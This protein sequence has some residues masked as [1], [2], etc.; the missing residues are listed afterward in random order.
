MM[1]FSVISLFPEMIEQGLSGLVAS[2]KNKGLYDLKVCDLRSFGKGVHKAVDDQIYGGTD[3][4]LLQAEPLAE[5]LQA[6]RNSDPDMQDA[7][8]VFLSP[9][10]QVWKQEKAVQWAKSSAPKILIC[11]RYAGVDQ[12]FIDQHC[13]LEISIGDFILNGGELAA[14]V[15]MESVIR[16]KEGALGN[17][18]SAL[19]DSHSE[20]L[21][22]LLEAPQFTRPK[23][24][25]GQQVPEVLMSGHH[26]NIKH[27]NQN[28][29]LLETAFK[30]PDLLNPQAKIQ[31]KALL[32]SKNARDIQSLKDFGLEKIPKVLEVLR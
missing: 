7:E 18:T 9:K 22:G 31:L 13:D 25:Q 15:L 19:Q 2:A 3:G 28:L 1:K 27:W 30:R 14:L 32:D 17:E 12:R 10:G 5:A 6:V 20:S 21:D 4:M 23:E 16:L 26:E 29:S 11:G 8:V 24:W